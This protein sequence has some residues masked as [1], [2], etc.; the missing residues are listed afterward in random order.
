M[1]Y[2]NIVNLLY[3][4]IVRC[5]KRFGSAKL[6]VWQVRAAK[7]PLALVAVAVLEIYNDNAGAL[8]S[9]AV[10]Q[11]ISGGRRIEA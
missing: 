11:F 3:D 10:V 1:E 5:V 6:S 4:T 2:V 9:D 8:F 7:L